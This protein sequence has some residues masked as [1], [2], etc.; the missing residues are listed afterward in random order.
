MSPLKVVTLTL[1]LTQSR[2]ET[3]YSPS[4]FLR[5]SETAFS[6]AKKRLL[7][8]TK[9]LLD[10]LHH[11]ALCKRAE[12][13]KRPLHHWRT[14]V[15]VRPWNKHPLHDLIRK[16]IFFRNLAFTI[17][18]THRKH[19]EEPRPPNK[20]TNIASKPNYFWNIS[21]IE[22]EKLLLK[23]ITMGEGLCSAFS[24]TWATLR[25]KF[26]RQLIR[27][28]FS[29]E[30]ISLPARP[31]TNLN[32]ASLGKHVVTVFGDFFL[33]L[34]V[35]KAEKNNLVF[36]KNQIFDLP[37]SMSFE[38]ELCSDDRTWRTKNLK[39]FG[40]RLLARRSQNAA[41]QSE[42]KNKC[43]FRRQM[44]KIANSVMKVNQGNY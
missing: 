26:D 35:L 39:L 20:Q 6:S 23:R 37:Y 43:V 44:W 10:H 11:D 41:R 33:G 25:S 42:S 32:A 2:W 7:Q 8:G 34:E 4:L 24:F 21:Q 18:E 9:L 1:T 12:T 27:Q 30:P 14:R 17:E 31:F 19:I 40:S 5:T 13:V 15:F 38:G 22:S 3:P 28:Q 29:F 36:E 16:S